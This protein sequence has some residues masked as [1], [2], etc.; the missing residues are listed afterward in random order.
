MNK[1]WTFGDSFVAGSQ[2][3]HRNKFTRKAEKL[4]DSVINAHC[5]GESE[6][7]QWS[8]T[9]HLAKYLNMDGINLG[10]GGL[11]NSAIINAV[12][13]AYGNIKDDDCVLISFSTPIIQNGRSPGII[14]Y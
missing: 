4:G 9:P 3:A 8:F 5:I 12:R 13:L 6:S 14:I 2:R 11:D 7:K 1:L 10:K